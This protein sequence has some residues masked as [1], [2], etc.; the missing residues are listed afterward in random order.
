MAPFIQLTK[1]D[2][3]FSSRIEANY[4]AFQYL[5][6]SFI[7]TPLLIHADLSKPFVLKIN[8]FDFTM[9]AMLL[10]LRENNLLH[11]VIFHFHEF[12]LH[13]LITRFMIKKTYSHCGCL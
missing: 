9:G 3:P 11:H 6:V 13:R 5:K 8:I 2:Q 7:T 10:Q 1:K 12:F 4:N